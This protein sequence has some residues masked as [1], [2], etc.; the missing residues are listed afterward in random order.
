MGSIVPFKSTHFRWKGSSMS[1]VEKDKIYE[2]KK[3]EHKPGQRP[4]FHFINRKGTLSKWY[5]PSP[6]TLDATL[7]ATYLCN[8]KKVLK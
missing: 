6:H 4:I 3:W 2:I 1:W 5:L 8:L 7:D